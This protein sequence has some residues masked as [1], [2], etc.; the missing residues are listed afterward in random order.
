MRE[1]GGGS[2]YAS[3]AFQEKRK[4]YGM[5]CS[6]SRKG[7]CWDNAPTENWFNSF[8]NERVHGLRYDT[9]VSDDGGVKYIEV[10]Y[11]RTWRHSILGYPSPMQFLDNR[12]PAQHEENLWHKTCP[13]ENEK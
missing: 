7:N 11:S 13:M 4:A 1:R 8:K 9:R 5:V 12:H 3:Q 2:Q 10:F 6:M